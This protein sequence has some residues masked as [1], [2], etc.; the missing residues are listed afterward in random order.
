M[1]ELF[2]TIAFLF[3]LHTVDLHRVGLGHRLAGGGNSW[4]IN[5]QSEDRFLIHEW[6]LKQ[7]LLLCKY[8]WLG[9]NVKCYIYISDKQSRNYER[10]KVKVA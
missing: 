5:V 2:L 10:W 4:R 7:N 1:P 8:S 3:V 9:R 6:S